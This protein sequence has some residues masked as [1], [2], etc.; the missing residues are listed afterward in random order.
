MGI[1]LGS[2]FTV[3]TN[4]PID[5]RMVFADTTAR[6]A[7]DTGRRYQ[8]L[9]AY[10]VADTTIY[11][12]QGGTANGNWVALGVLTSSAQSIT[13]VKTF[14]TGINL[15]GYLEADATE[16]DSTS[17]GANQTLALF[18]KLT[19]KV[20]SGTL[21]SIA[22]ITAPTNVRLGV[23]MNTG[24]TAITIRNQSAS[25]TAGNRIIT[26]TGGD[27][28]LKDGASLWFAYD[29]LSTRWRIVG[30]SGGGSSTVFGSSASPRTVAAGTGITSGASHMSTVDQMQTV[31]I[32]GSGSSEVD[33]VTA[34]PQIQAHTLDDAEMTIKGS[35]SMNPVTFTNGTGLVLTEPIV[36]GPDT[37]LKLRFD[38]SANVWKEQAR[39]N[40]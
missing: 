2:N 30:G 34:N 39:N 25:A 3:N 18:T 10:V 26:G 15:V 1:V 13:G 24:G 17:T 38:L 32:T 5:D 28:I 20:N 37:I 4:L 19:K 29:T 33:G 7:L 8:G 6:N 9:M 12:L 40:L 22:G 16:E 27:I 21:T 36:F 31:Y 11:Q 14:Q 35:T 23:L